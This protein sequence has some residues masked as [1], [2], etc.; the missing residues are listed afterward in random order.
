MGLPHMYIYINYI[1]LWTAKQEILEN[2]DYR[3]KLCLSWLSCTEQIKRAYRQLSE[4]TW[5]RQCIK[6]IKNS[7]HIRNYYFFFF[8]IFL[9][10]IDYCYVVKAWQIATVW[11]YRFATSY[12]TVWSSL[13][14][15][16]LFYQGWCLYKCSR[17]C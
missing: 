1:W 15:L 6:E 5:R 8:Y 7:M 2:W 14:H 10:Y 4:V 16:I 3:F 9:Y 12:K 13:N 17:A 11:W